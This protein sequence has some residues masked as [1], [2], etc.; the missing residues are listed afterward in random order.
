MNKGSRRVLL[1]LGA[2]LAVAGAA[3]AVT[4]PWD[5]DVQ[6]AGASAGAS[7]SASSPAE[8]SSGGA[9]PE[10]D[11]GG[12]PAAATSSDPGADAPVLEDDEPADAAVVITYREFDPTTDS[13]NVGAYVAGVLEIGGECVLELSDGT[14]T[15]RASMDAEP[16]AR[17]T[18]CGELT[19]AGL[20][21]GEWSGAVVYTSPDGD[22]L[23]ADVTVEVP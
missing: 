9:A 5:D 21:P 18:S 7:S 20:T 19:L 13:V 8:E 16:D 12:S 6:P 3:V 23:S 4:T 1:G 11:A 22:E 2:V 15:Q 10:T 14:T 17:T